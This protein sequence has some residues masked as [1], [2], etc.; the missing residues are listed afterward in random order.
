MTGTP[1]PLVCPPSK[2]MLNARLLVE[3]RYRNEANDLLVHHRD[4]FRNWNGQAWPATEDHGI[5]AAVWKYFEHAEYEK[6]DKDGNVEVLPFNPN[7]DK[8]GNIVEALEA[9]THLDQNVGIPSWLDE[10]DDPVDQYVAM[11]N[12]ILHVPSREL[13]DPTPHLFTPYALPYGYDPA[14]PQPERFLQFLDELWPE[15]TESRLTVQ[16]MIGYLLVP[17]TSQ[18]KIFLVVGPRRSGKGTIARLIRGLLGD[19]NVAGPTLASLTTNFG[20][21]ALI[22]R[23]VAIF[24]DARIDSRSNGAVVTERL[25]T[26]SGEDAITIDRKYRDLWTGILPT[27]LIVISNE[28]PRLS[29]TS[30]ALASRFVVLRTDRSFLGKEDTGLTTALLQK[31]PG[32]LNWALDGLDRLNERGHFLQPATSDNVIK[33][34]EDLASPV[35]VFLRDC[36][37]T[38]P[39]HSTSVKDIYAA[40]RSWCERNGH[41]PATAQTFGRDLRS[42]LPGIETT[43]RRTGHNNQRERVYQGLRLI[44]RA[45]WT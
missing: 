11:D 16:E 31:L 32:I 4:M 35:S 28:L 20:L 12:G 37:D 30:G 33:D 3:F 36:C 14:A 27:R 23:P 40:Y 42:I 45:G 41:R 18:Q 38:D 39:S 5:R 25:L 6:T 15:D 9:A 43:Q 24:S 29:D 26:I 34:M 19:H 22:D 44:D 17:D 7:K 2:P 10:R 13:L 1:R 8:V 21:Q